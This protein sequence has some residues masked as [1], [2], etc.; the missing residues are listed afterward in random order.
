MN[1]L[2]AKLPA[3]AKEAEKINSQLTVEPLSNIL[4]KISMEIDPD[5]HRLGY[6]RF[7]PGLWVGGNQYHWRQY[8]VL[9]YLAREGN[10]LKLSYCINIIPEMVA[11]QLDHALLLD[12]IY[13][14]NFQS[15]KLLLKFAKDQL[16]IVWDSRITTQIMSFLGDTQTS[17][18]LPLGLSLRD[19]QIQNADLRLRA[20]AKP[21][22][23]IE[24][25]RHQYPLLYSRLH[26]EEQLIESGPMGMLTF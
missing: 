14:G 10:Y 12:A 9:N 13:S 16:E 19:N 11:I 6:F 22:Q 26:F 15:V 5:L 23:L 21:N 1:E 18:L 24:V 4:N 25:A 7:C 20:I 8:G 3:V 17:Q 2:S